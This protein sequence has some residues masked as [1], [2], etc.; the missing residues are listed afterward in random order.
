[1]LHSSNPIKARF[2]AKRAATL[3]R[4]PSGFLVAGLLVL[5]GLMWAVMLFGL[6]RIF[7]A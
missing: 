4:F 1:V 7:R 2:S 5:S 6:S 3:K